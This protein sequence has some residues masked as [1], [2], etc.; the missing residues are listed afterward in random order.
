MPPLV[1]III[2]TRNSAEFLEKC[3][4]SIKNQSY[5]N[6]E[7]IVVDNNSTD[8]TEEVA[9]K[10]VN[11]FIDVGKIKSFR[12]RFSATFQRNY[13]VKKSKGEIVYYFD[14]D[15][16]MDKNVI[17]D[18]VTLILNNQADVIIIPE[19]SFGTSFWAKCKQLERRC[20]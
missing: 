7:V 3:L 5:K 8:N 19:D 2:P 11:Q 13:G 20:Y 18:C 10:Y 15:M 17:K 9:K 14:A 16:V 4:S 6:I 12:G 1:S